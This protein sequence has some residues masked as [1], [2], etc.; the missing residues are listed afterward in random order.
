MASEGK[1]VGA[2][3]WALRIT[4]GVMIAGGLAFVSCTG[5]RY[6]AIR[7]FAPEYQRA[8]P[9]PPLGEKLSVRF[10][11]P[12]AELPRIAI[13]LNPVGQGF[14]QTTDLQPFPGL[15]DLMIVLEKAGTAK[16]LSL[17]TGESGTWFQ[18]SVLDASE[19]GLLG[20][21]FHP[22]FLENGLFYLN[23]VTSSGG[24]DVTRVAE[25]SIPAGGDPRKV[26]PSEL[27]RIIEVAQPYQNHNAGQ[28]QFGPDGLLY[29]GLGDGG[30]ANDPHGH[31]QDPNTLLGAMLRLDVDRKDPGKEYAIPADNPFVGRSGYRPEL[32]A[33]GLRNPWRYAFDPAGRMIAGDVG[34]DRFEEIDLVER[35]ANLGWNQR[36]A[37]HCFKP[38]EGCKVEGMTEPIFEY[39]RED[40]GSVTGGYVALGEAVPELRGKYVF[41][42]FL[43]GSLWALDL[44]SAAGQKAKAFTLGRWPI[45]PSTFGR[46]ASGALYVSDYPDG[47]IYRIDAAPAGR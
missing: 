20:I 15:P 41:G 19:Q 42:D 29:V 46:D 2:G 7:V 43:T 5:V 28:L 21:A 33:T 18:V 14:I 44:P 35:G 36:E 9:E 22:R 25:W 39:G 23:Y 8:P 32:W 47:V 27:R 4:L 45:L 37:S 38:E 34:Q 13:E 3:L 17:G 30:W 31:G 40:G 1:R 11:G 24:A 6:Q 26:R 16:W 12:S 10:D